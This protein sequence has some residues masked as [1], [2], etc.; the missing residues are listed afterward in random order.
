MMLNALVWVSGLD[1]PAEGV[2]SA[3]TAEDLIANQ[4]PKGQKN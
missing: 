1:V 4:D 3:P 2:M